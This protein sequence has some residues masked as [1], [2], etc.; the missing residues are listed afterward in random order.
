MY[1]EVIEFELLN[2][3]KIHLKF[4]NGKNGSIDFTEYLKKGGIFSKFSDI[5]FFKQVYIN[6]E[7]GVLTWPGGIDI[8][9]E[10]IYSKATGEPLPDW[11]ETTK[12]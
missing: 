1:C 7:F 8:A 9:P 12:N 3:Y 2:E 6:P 11:I 5:N 10:T 4:K